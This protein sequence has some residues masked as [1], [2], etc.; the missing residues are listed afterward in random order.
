MTNSLSSLSAAPFPPML[1]KG[2]Y[3]F[4]QTPTFCQTHPDSNHD[5]NKAV[6]LSCRQTTD[7]SLSRRPSL[8]YISHVYISP[9]LAR[10]FAQP[11]IRFPM[12]EICASL[13]PVTCKFDIFSNLCVILSFVAGLGLLGLVFRH[14]LLL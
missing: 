5:S 13:W 14:V 11:V 10:C 9:C 2:L 6:C 12:P 8:A 3:F 4:S 1:N 7:I